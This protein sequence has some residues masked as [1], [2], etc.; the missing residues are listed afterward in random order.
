[1]RI[2]GGRLG[3]LASDDRLRDL[4]A[5][6]LLL[7]TLL[8]ITQ[9]RVLFMTSLCLLEA[10]SSQQM[11]M[12]L[13][14]SQEVAQSLQGCLDC[15][16]VQRSQDRV[17]I[18]DVN[19]RDETICLHTQT[20]SS[21]DM[22]IVGVAEIRPGSWETHRIQRTVLIHTYSMSK[23]NI[24]IIINI[25][26]PN[27]QKYDTLQSTIKHGRRLE[28]PQQKNPVCSSSVEGALAETRENTRTL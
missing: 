27:K 15:L 8:L 23:K 14:S 24:I 11:Q 13:V 19:L 6:L 17:S 12:M 28:L 21:Q 4:T 22:P 3:P 1:M 10:L 9:T 25:M 5:E 26:Q 2:D 16:P 18:C 7:L 20:A